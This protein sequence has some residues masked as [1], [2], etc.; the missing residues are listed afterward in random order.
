[1]LYMI[2]TIISY[3]TGDNIRLILLRFLII[4]IFD[5]NHK[6]MMMIMIMM[7]MM[8]LMIM[9]MIMMMIMM[10]MILKITVL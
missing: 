10:M 4:N 2:Y 7:M 3:V 1:M 5:D 8:I 6:K 9:I